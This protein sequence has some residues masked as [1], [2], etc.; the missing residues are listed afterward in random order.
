[1]SMLKWNR[2][3]DTKI[4][5]QYRETHSD[6][7]AQWVT[8][9]PCCRSLTNC[10]ASS[11]LFCCYLAPDNCQHI[12]CHDDLL[13]ERLSQPWEYKCHGNMWWASIRARCKPCVFGANLNYKKIKGLND[14]LLYCLFL[15]VFPATLPQI[16][17]WCP[18][19]N[20]GFGA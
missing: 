14:S 20:K 19:S 8:N 12:D 5:Q 15:Q 3:L 11:S 1:M 4:G 13:K 9:C 7:K 6:K 2:S 17:R 10:M 18:L 16:E